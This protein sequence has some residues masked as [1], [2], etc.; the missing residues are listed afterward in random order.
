MVDDIFL[1]WCVLELI[2]FIDE[3][4]FI[5]SDEISGI[6]IDLGL[7]FFI[8]PIIKK[9]TE[10]KSAGVSQKIQNSTG[11]T[12]KA[13]TED[14]IAYD[15]IKTDYIIFANNDTWRIKIIETKTQKIV[16][17]FQVGSPKRSFMHDALLSLGFKVKK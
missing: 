3:R 8:P 17:S 10:Q 7:Q 1:C 4:I 15:E 2:L 12:E 11:K 16:A 13:I 9:F 14:Y 6:L 5:I